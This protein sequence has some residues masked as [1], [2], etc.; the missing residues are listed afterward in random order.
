MSKGIYFPPS[1]FIALLSSSFL[2]G[3]ISTPNIMA[4]MVECS[5]AKRPLGRS[6]D[7]FLDEILSDAAVAERID[8]LL[9]GLAPK[10]SR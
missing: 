1:N 2:M 10:R 8:I 6:L 3:G 9:C 7:A 5:G 4:T